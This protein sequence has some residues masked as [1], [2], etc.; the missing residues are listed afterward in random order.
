MTFYLETYKSYA[1]YQPF[2]VIIK[3][4]LLPNYPIS[5]WKNDPNV[6]SNEVVRRSINNFVLGA[7]L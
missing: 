5:H 3:L 7:V 4:K 2:K 6:I 1:I